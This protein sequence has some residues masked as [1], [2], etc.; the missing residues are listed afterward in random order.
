LTDRH[1]PSL[2]ILPSTRA[3]RRSN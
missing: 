3:Q 2:S 1:H